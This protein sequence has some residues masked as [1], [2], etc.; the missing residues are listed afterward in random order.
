M[1]FVLGPD[2][3]DEQLTRACPNA[4]S[5]DM[6]RAQGMSTATVMIDAVK[7]FEMVRWQPLLDEAREVGYPMRLVYM[8]L[9]SYEQPRLLQAYD[10]VS[11]YQFQHIA[12]FGRQQSIQSEKSAREALCDLSK[13]PSRHLQEPSRGLQGNSKTPQDTPTAALRPS[14]DTS[15]ASQNTSNTP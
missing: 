8:L 10:S 5:T 13:R 2:R 11:D 9:A 1:S 3:V 6:A 12:S 15:K 7:C 4:K 14:K